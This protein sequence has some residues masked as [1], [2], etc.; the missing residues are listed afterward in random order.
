MYVFFALA[1]S[2]VLCWLLLRLPSVRSRGNYLVVASFFV[3]VAGLTLFNLISR[4]VG[5]D[6]GPGRSVSY[7][8]PN[9]YLARDL[10]GLLALAVYAVACASPAVGLLALRLFTRPGKRVPG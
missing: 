2:C 1:T 8:I 3:L 9:D 10:T 6:L 5:I 7:N 4:A